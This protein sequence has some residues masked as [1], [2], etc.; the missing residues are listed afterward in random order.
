MNEIDYSRERLLKVAEGLLDLNQ[1]EINSK[2]VFSTSKIEDEEVKDLL[3]VFPRIEPFYIGHGASDNYAFPFLSSCQK[4]NPTG[5]DILNSLKVKN[6]KSEHLK[7]I[8]ADYIKHPG[9]HP[10]TL[11]DEI[12]N[13]SKK[14]Y[15]FSEPTDY[16]ENYIFVSDHIHES[17]KELVEENKL[18]YI[19]LHHWIKK[20]EEPTEYMSLIGNKELGY[21]VSKGDEVLLLAIGFLKGS[22]VLAGYISFQICH[23][24]CD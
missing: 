1:N 8:Q 22:K 24:L 20:I 6:F 12:H 9:Y 18:W 15:L 3:N 10:R 17:L 19:T 11:N 21:Y 5:K 2:V 14:Q 23:N 7:N 4:R 16:P 13:Q